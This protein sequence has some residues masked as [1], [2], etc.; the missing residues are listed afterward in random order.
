MSAG[1]AARVGPTRR[2]PLP[3]PCPGS[4]VGWALPCSRSARGPGPLAHVVSC[5]VSTRWG[6]LPPGV[7]PAPHCWCCGHPQTHCSFPEPCLGVASRG[8]GVRPVCVVWWSWHDFRSPRPRGGGG[9]GPPVL[10]IAELEAS[11]IRLPVVPVFASAASRCTKGAWSAR[12]L[13]FLSRR[14]RPVPAPSNLHP[15]LCLF[16]LAFGCF[17]FWSHFKRKDKYRSGRRCQLLSPSPDGEEQGSSHCPPRATDGETAPG[18]P[19][20]GGQAAHGQRPARPHRS[21]CTRRRGAPDSPSQTQGRS[22][23]PEVVLSCGYTPAGPGRC[24][25]ALPSHRVTWAR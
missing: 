23:C 13:G 22:T 16:S 4:P 24:G 15:P 1:A 17:N 12:R 2:Q 10:D 25:R 14:P 19:R 20:R 21:L 7:S 18:K 8:A 5:S 3:P 6:G 11:L 9:G